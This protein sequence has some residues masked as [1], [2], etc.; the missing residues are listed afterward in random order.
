MSDRLLISSGVKFR[1]TI[2]L[3]AALYCLTVLAEGSEIG[4]CT[5]AR[6]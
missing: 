5:A 3:R 1:S 6:V 4:P 2:L